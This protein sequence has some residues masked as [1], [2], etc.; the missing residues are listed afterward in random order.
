MAVGDVR[1]LGRTLREHI[2]G[3]WATPWALFLVACP[4]N[5]IATISAGSAWGS[6]A[7]AFVAWIEVALASYATA[8]VVLLLA[9]VTALRHRRE[10]PVPIGV[11]VS[12]GAVIG[13]VRAF[14][15]VALEDAADIAE[16]TASALV[17]SSLN[18]IVMGA[19][20]LPL[21]AL[22]TSLVMEYREQ[23]AALVAERI[24]W[25]QQRRRLEGLSRELR[26]TLLAAVTSDLDA[27]LAAADDPEVSS[28]SAAQVVGAVGREL[29]ATSPETVGSRLRVS[30]ILRAALHERPFVIQPM[31]VLWLPASIAALLRVEA[32]PV[33]ALQ[34][35]TAAVIL[36]TTLIAGDRVRRRWPAHTLTI[37]VGTLVVAWVLIAPGLWLLFGPFSRPQ[38]PGLWVNSAAFL[39]LTL[40][41]TSL[42]AA[43]LRSG[44]NVLARL[45]SRASDAE[46]AALA[47]EAELA[48]TRRALAIELHGPVRSRLTAAAALLSGL[49]AP[50]GPS[51]REALATALAALS[52]SAPEAGT[53]VADAL[54]AACAPWGGVVSATVQ[55]PALESRLAPLLGHAV[56]EAIANAYRHGRATTVTITVQASP[57]GLSLQVA[58][59]GRG[60]PASVTPGLGSGL[61]TSLGEWTL[62]ARPQ[63]GSVLTLEIDDSGH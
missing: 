23:R 29:W 32:P 31:V 20:S 61:L 43:S 25:E 24:A 16:A 49:Q 4:L 26:A 27:A 57:T 59:N 47:A 48:E 14:V 58:D 51:A 3:R 30:T 40:V 50:G 62:R 22:A 9:S 38:A 1:V 10:H 33:A 60:A 13:L 46:I 19:I 21:A 45:R 53:M 18:G 56:D 39:T 42:A 36:W 34:A 37:A 52:E 55:C 7:S 41:L 12:V 15:L 35:A 8:G 54:H 6:D 28:S 11:V 63:G 5:L 2:G 17:I 44:E